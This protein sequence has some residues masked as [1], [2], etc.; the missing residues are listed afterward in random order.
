MVSSLRSGV[1]GQLEV[2]KGSQ[3]DVI[4]DKHHLAVVNGWWSMIDIILLWS[5]V[6]GHL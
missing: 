2:A 5:V 6:G 1:G 4:S 3:L